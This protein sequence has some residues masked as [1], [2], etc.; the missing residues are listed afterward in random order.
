MDTD[1]LVVS[2]DIAH[3][4]RDDLMNKKMRLVEIIGVLSG[5]WQQFRTKCDDLNW[6]HVD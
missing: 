3:E 1:K 4:T 2:L 5:P 6:R